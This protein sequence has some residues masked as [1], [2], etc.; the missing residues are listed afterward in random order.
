MVE[1]GLVQLGLGVSGEET[2]EG[3]AHSGEELVGFLGEVHRA[4][5]AVHHAG[6]GHSFA[7]GPVHQE[8]HD[9]TTDRSGGR[10]YRGVT[11]EARSE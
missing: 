4:V 6:V 5:V 10:E 3:D 2:L 1:R 7:I 9:R 8:A 11:V